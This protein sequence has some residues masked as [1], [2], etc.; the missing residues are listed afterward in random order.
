MPMCRTRPR[1]RPR[2]RFAQ[3][4]RSTFNRPLERSSTRN[5][6]PFIGFFDALSVL[7]GYK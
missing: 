2:N 6:S 7:E 5:P 1:R 3:R 4:F